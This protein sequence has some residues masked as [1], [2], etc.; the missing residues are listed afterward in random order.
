MKYTIIIIFI[1]VTFICY[2]YKRNENFT[3]FKFLLDDEIQQ[4]KAIIKDI[5]KYIVS[6]KHNMK[7]LRFNGKTILLR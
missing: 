1:L 7:A 4:D 6:K 3:D 2:Y 5:G